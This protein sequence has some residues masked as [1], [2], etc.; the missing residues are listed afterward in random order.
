MIANYPSR[1]AC[2]NSSR[3]DVTRDN[4]LSSDHSTAA[5]MHTLQ[6]ACSKT[7]PDLIIN[8]YVTN[9]NMSPFLTTVSPI[10]HITNPMLW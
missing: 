5:D 4:G 1:I 6:D 9:P 8:C 7:D 2:D 3:R 10:N